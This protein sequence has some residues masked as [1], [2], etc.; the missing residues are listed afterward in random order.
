V[1]FALVD[2]EQV[3]AIPKLKGFCAGCGNPVTAKCGKQRMWHWAHDA[4]ENCDRWW[5]TETEW[6]RSWKDKFPR[7]WQEKIHH[8]ATGEKHIA[9]VKTNHGL[10]IEFQHSY[11]APQERELRERFYGN[12]VWVVDGTRLKNDFPRF[13][14][15]QDN[16]RK[17]HMKGFFLASF[18]EEFLPSAWLESKVPVIFDFRGFIPSETLDMMRESLWC[19]LPGRAEG[20]AV[21]GRFA[22]AS[23]VSGAS[24]RAQLLRPHEFIESFTRILRRERYRGELEA[25]KLSNRMYKRKSSQAARF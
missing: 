25:K 5:E 10:V 22:R 24:D 23:F 16:L 13:L 1:R 6:H 20:R 2:N 21:I 11:L 4:R 7:E 3:E 15:G 18:S 17:T 8:D 19:L 12:M 9:D 14:K